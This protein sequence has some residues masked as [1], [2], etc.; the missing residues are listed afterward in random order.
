MCSDDQVQAPHSEA[1][2]WTVVAASERL[3]LHT[4][5]E[6]GEVVRVW[7]V[8]SGS[9]SLSL[10]L[11]FG[12]VTVRVA[13]SSPKAFDRCN[14]NIFT[15]PCNGESMVAHGSRPGSLLGPTQILTFDL[16][17]QASTTV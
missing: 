3:T 14:Q 9:L 1:K 15:Q 13:E 5:L 11:G 10:S 17:L 2:R 16:S 6:V 7:R 8:G 12:N 4:C